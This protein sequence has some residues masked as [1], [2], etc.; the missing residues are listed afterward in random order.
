MFVAAILQLTNAYVY[1]LIFYIEIV[2]IASLAILVMHFGRWDN[3]NC[4]VNYTIEEVIFRESSSYDELY[5]VIAMQLGIDMKV[6]KLKI[7]YKIE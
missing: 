6:N 7:E 1:N 5:N 4:Y 3:D 2:K